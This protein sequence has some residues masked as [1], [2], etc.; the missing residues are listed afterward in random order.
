MSE[1][2][3]GMVGHKLANA[4]LIFAAGMALAAVIAAVA[5]LLGVLA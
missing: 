1:Q 2:N 5:H 4:A 3:A